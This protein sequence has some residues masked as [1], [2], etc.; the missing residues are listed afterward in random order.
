MSRQRSI[1]PLKRGVVRIRPPQCERVA[2]GGVLVDALHVVTCAHVVATALDEDR[3][4]RQEAPREDE[5][6]D[7]HFPF[8]GGEPDPQRRARVIAWRPHPDERDEPGDVAVLRLE[9]PAPTGAMAPP[10]LRAASF[11]GRAFRAYAFPP[12]KPLGLIPSGVIA[13]ARGLGGTAPQLTYLEAAAPPGRGHSGG[14]VWDDELGAVIGIV[15]EAFKD[16]MTSFV[17]PVGVLVDTWPE[18][19]R[20]IGWR[21]QFAGDDEAHWQRRAR[22]AGLPTEEPGDLFVGRSAALTE[23]AAFANGSEPGL[24]VVT[25]RRG[26]GKSAVLARIVM[27]ADPD[28]HEEL[29]RGEAR[30]AETPGEGAVAAAIVAGP[31]TKLQDVV[32]EIARWTQ[33]AA[34][35][36]H[37]LTNALRDRGDAPPLV[38]V[39][40]VEDA[41]DPGNLVD[42][43]LVPLTEAG[44]IRLVVGLARSEDGALAER[45]L[46]VGVDIDLDAEYL[47]DD[48]MEAYVRRLLVRHG[49]EHFPDEAAAE[50]PAKAVVAKATPSFVV[51]RLSALAA[52]AGGPSEGGYPDD[53]AKALDRAYVPALAERLTGDPLERTAKEH[54]LRALLAAL[55]YG[56]GRGLPL[57]GPVWSTIAAT[58]GERAFALDAGRGLL[59]TPVGLILERVEVGGRPYVRLFHEALDFSLRHGRDRAVT[60]RAIADALCEL[61]PADTDDPA[62]PYI[63]ENL[64]RHVATGAA[65]DELAER[66]HVLDRLD[67]AAV[68]RDAIGPALTAAAVP[69]RIVGA[70][71]AHRPAEGDDRRSRTGLRQ[72]G[73]AQAV[74]TRGFPPGDAPERLPSWTLRSAVVRQHPPHLRLPAGAP[75]Q[76]LTHV[77][78]SGGLRLIA[79]GG[80]DGV[81]RVWSASTG[82]PFGDP[83]PSRTGSEPDPI[84]ALAACRRGERTCIVA[85][86][87]GGWI[88]LWDPL[89]AA[90]PDEL[91]SP[92]EAIRAVGAFERGGRVRV[93]VAGEQDDVVVLDEEGGVVAR[94]RGKRSMRGIATLDGELTRIFGAC[95]DSRVRLWEL[96]DDEPDEPLDPVRTYVG[97][98][99]W[100]R[101]VCTVGDERL[102]A[103]GD[104]GTLPVWTSGNPTPALSRR[105]GHDRGVL[106]VAACV[107]DGG[108]RIATSGAD[109]LVRLW[110]TESGERLLD[111]S[112]HAGAVRAL[113]TFTSGDS[114]RVASGGD[115][116]TVR[117]W[118]PDLTAEPDEP[119]EWHD[120]PVTAVAMVR[121]RVVTGSADGTIRRWNAENGDALT[122]PL[123]AGDG[124]VAFVAADP[125]DPPSDVVAVGVK[126]RVVFLDSTS[127]RE[128]R[129]PLV[130]HVGRVRSIVFGLRHGEQEV[131]ATGAEDGSVRVWDAA[132]GDP[133][134]ELR[135][136]V[137]GPV[138]DLA[139]VAVPG[140]GSC[141]A[142]VGDE[143]S[144][145]LRS[146]GDPRELD[147]RLRGHVD[148][149]MTVCTTGP[150]D[151]PRLVTGAD[152]Y[153][154]RSWDPARRLPHALLGRH[155]GPVRVAEALTSPPGCVATG[156]D[157]GVVCV[158][159]LDA[160]RRTHRIDLGSRVH[161]LAATEDGLVAGTDEGHVVIELRR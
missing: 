61:C 51:A 48:A 73:M 97:P 99:D 140:A 88:R 146:I 93:V 45:L 85:A 131:I 150:A 17:I 142:V 12:S 130:G 98:A 143:R 79:A 118:T 92:V 103:A 43:L 104:D 95:D 41:H 137:D 106:A 53:V 82:V 133:L 57:D 66:P 30:E 123:P 87:A 135:S 13:G 75:V 81:V 24:R 161:A 113:A 52:A 34:T 44:A 78:A 124:P 10:L 23:L 3:R 74:A 154:V 120:C 108:A 59:E 83:L 70:A 100:L 28:H 112:G 155:E 38:V 42:K 91:K 101:S 5:V 147:D 20:R 27:T 157:D 134:P 14:P 25:G 156:G 31:E 84:R 22:G 62:D 86:T 39:D 127:G 149:I 76:A 64:T 94:L 125:R 96:G 141:L 129:K 119:H 55:A 50:E 46:E 153:T 151:A 139:S 107:T 111:L 60:D 152:D 67:F 7:V 49:A 117:L 37:E 158:W 32:T 136:N 21:V 109:G 15:T 128:A 105:T 8:L 148:W 26:S 63:E 102:A 89:S 121:G 58:V 114:L 47:D 68:R 18:L 77:L 6:V 72:L 33:V 19:G 115:D 65:W 110:E 1:D 160:R 132:T 54:E 80:A 4:Y 138:R 159:D 29:L 69:K 56:H 126:N 71:R 90:P 36:V 116:A 145:G 144:F 2:G 9:S 16:A 40:Q 35:S 122:D 11:D